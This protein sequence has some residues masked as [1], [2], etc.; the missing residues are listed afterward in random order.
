MRNSRDLCSRSVKGGELA[1][2]DDLFHFYSMK[3]VGFFEGSFKIDPFLS[4]YFKAGGSVFFNPRRKG[5]EQMFG[6]FFF[7]IF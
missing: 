1:F 5:S 3:K 4:E 7:L 2:V 6:D